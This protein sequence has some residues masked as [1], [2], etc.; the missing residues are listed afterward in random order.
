MASCEVILL[1]AAN[2]KPTK[3]N[4][5]MAKTRFTEIRLGAI[6]RKL[7]FEMWYVLSQMSNNIKKFEAGERP[8]RETL[9]RQRTFVELF[10]RHDRNLLRAIKAANRID[11]CENEADRHYRSKDSCDAL[12][13]FYALCEFFEK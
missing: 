4:Y 5:I 7:E 1:D 3:Q 12:C 2:N 13:K 9:M 11:R 8:A 6:T 10:L